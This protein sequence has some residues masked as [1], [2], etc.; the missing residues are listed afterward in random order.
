MSRGPSDLAAVQWLVY[1]FGIAVTGL[2]I[3]II[4][5]LVQ[6]TRRH[7]PSINAGDE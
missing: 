4:V 5:Y 6:L 3:Y 2:L 1:P 7:P